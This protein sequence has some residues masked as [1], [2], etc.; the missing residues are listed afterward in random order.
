M[1]RE[2]VVVFLYVSLVLLWEFIILTSVTWDTV[3]HPQRWWHDKCF[4]C[5]GK[6]HYRC[7]M[8]HPPD[9]LHTVD[10]LY[11]TKAAAHSEAGW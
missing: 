7:E 2:Q 4:V 9:R 8:G 11:M 1:K 5:W 10:E 3:L 6:S